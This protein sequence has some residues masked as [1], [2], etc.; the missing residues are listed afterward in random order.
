M[1]IFSKYKKIKN[2]NQRNKWI[3]RYQLNFALP[4]YIPNT[5][6][7][8]DN[9]VLSKTLDFKLNQIFLEKGSPIYANSIY[10]SFV[11]RYNSFHVY[12]SKPSL[13]LNKLY[14][15]YR[16]IHIVR[17]FTKFQVR[18]FKFIKFRA[19]AGREEKINKKKKRQKKIHCTGLLFQGLRLRSKI[20]T[21]QILHNSGLYDK[22]TR[23]YK[24]AK[25]RFFG[26]GSQHTLTKKA[27]LI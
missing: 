9:E 6:L 22:R 17:N 19:A 3:K 7:D 10:S 13:Y 15:L 4:K 18:L 2:I 16:L 23:L 8:S 24:R 25:R 5:F 11:R 26:N 20:P 12:T 21:S 14:I 1:K 27:F